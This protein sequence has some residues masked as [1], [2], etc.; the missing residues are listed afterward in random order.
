M[1]LDEFI[2]ELFLHI[3]AKDGVE[4]LKELVK[5]EMNDVSL[6]YSTARVESQVLTDD[7]NFD[8]KVEISSEHYDDGEIIFIDYYLKK[9]RIRV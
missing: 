5:T 7:K 3:M 1:S 4:K 8:P 9:W 2:N 6:D